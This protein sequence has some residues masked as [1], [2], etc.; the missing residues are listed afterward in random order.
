LFAIVNKNLYPSYNTVYQKKI[1]NPNDYEE[2]SIDELSKKI[3]E[4]WEEFR[5]GDL[6]KIN[7][8]MENEWKD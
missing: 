6:V 2:A 4:K 8:Y 7:E 3:N 1:L 5:N